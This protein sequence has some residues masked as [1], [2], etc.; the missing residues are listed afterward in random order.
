MELAELVRI[1]T[2]EG[3]A[4]VTIDNPPM[5]VL[6]VQVV[7][8]L[9]EVFTSISNDPSI[10]S[11][12]LTGAGNRAFMAGA[13]IK[14]FP[15]WLEME[16]KELKKIIME[17]HGVF[18]LIDNL[19]KPTIAVLNGIA[20]G[21]GC[22]LALTCDIR[23]AEEQIKIGLPEVKLGLFPGGGGTQRLS[24]LIGPAKAKELM[25]LGD[26][27]TANEA[28]RLGIVNHVTANGEGLQTALTMAR[29]IGGY[30]IQALSR[31]KKSVN[32]G[33]DTS[34]AEGIEIES[35]L[36]TEVFKTEDIREG[37]Q[38]FIEKRTP[39]FKHR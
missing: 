7:K 10:I 22:E 1:K 30:S 28:L 17:T 35:N 3:I 24:R 29:K 25:F 39:S 26:P 9:G 16:K 31:I 6:S 32:E 19:P 11:V 12:I 27:V 14:E 38:A 15:S 20:L 18:N 36:F 4:I 13:D 33:V 2:T 5:N 34:F 8:E 21:G 37:V 23:I